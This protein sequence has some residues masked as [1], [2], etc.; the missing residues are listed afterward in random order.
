VQVMPTEYGTRRYRTMALTSGGLQVLNAQIILE[1]PS[2]CLKTAHVVTDRDGAV[3]FDKGC[4]GVYP[5]HLGMSV[6]KKLRVYL[7]TK[8]QKMYFTAADAHR[9]TT[10]PSAQ[11]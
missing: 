11:Q 3:G 7:A 1:P 10:P 4:M 9:E 2:D 5:L 8:E 6:L